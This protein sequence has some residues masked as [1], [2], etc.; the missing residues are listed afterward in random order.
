MKHMNSSG[1]EMLKYLEWKS[2]TWARDIVVLKWHVVQGGYGPE[3][4]EV[5]K[6]ILMALEL[7]EKAVR[8][9]M[10]LAHS[11]RV[12]RAA[13]NGIL[14][15]LL[16]D[17]ALAY[18]YEDLSPAVSSLVT[19]ARL[20]IDRPPDAHHDIQ[21]WRWPNYEEPRHQDLRFDPQI[22]PDTLKRR[23]EILVGEGGV[24]LE[25]PTCW[26]IYK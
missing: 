15:H 18:D 25:P 21:T 12:G 6:E 20:Y 4:L 22:A 8:D 11:R 14:W 17:K 2:L 26:R 3:A 19:N 24:P 9:L 23:F 1:G 13:A 16:S 10:L 7:D 5:W